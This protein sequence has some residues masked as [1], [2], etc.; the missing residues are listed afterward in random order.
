M[1]QTI[2]KVP[3]MFQADEYNTPLAKTSDIK[4]DTQNKYQSE[5]N[6]DLYLELTK[7][8][9]KSQIGAEGGIALL[10]E[11]G[12]IPASQLPED[13]FIEYATDAEIREMFNVA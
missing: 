2:I 5:V 10:D 9:D 12:K 3:G 8:V 11:N 13:V 6:D 7:K 1:A 4:D